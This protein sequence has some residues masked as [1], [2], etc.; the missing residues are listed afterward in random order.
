PVACGLWLSADA[1]AAA[2]GGRRADTPRRPLRAPGHAHADVRTTGARPEFLR[3]RWPCAEPVRISR[4]GVAGEFLG[5]LVRAM[6]PRDADALA[7]ATRTR[8][9]R[10]GRVVPVTRRTRGARAFPGR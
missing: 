2:R 9:R 1:A 3:C 4:Q 10:P 6:P 7:A 8:R 5:H